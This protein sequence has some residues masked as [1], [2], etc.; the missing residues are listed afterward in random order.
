MLFDRA[1]HLPRRA[2]RRAERDRRVRRRAL[3]EGDGRRR[4]ARRGG[5]TLALNRAASDLGPREGEYWGAMANLSY[6]SPK[7]TIKESSIQGRGL[8][9]AK[10]IRKGEVV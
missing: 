9:A 3:G 10:A 1:G 7:A 5:H 8:F 4:P 2:L 6:I